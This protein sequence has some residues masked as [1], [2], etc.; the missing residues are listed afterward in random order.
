MALYSGG[1]AGEPMQ[2]VKGEI[3]DKNPGFDVVL[4]AGT[5]DRNASFIKE[6]P[7][8]LDDGVAVLWTL[9]DEP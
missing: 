8:I 5:Y 2:P 4:M 1:N 7:V 9:K 3:R 6:N